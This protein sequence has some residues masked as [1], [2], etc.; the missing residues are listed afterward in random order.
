M[1]KIPFIFPFNWLKRLIFGYVIELW[2]FYQSDQ[3]RTIFT[4]L[5]PQHRPPP[6]NLGMTEFWPMVVPTHIHLIHCQ[7]ESIDWIRAILVGIEP[8]KWFWRLETKENRPN[9]HI[10]WAV[11]GCNRAKKLKKFG[12]E[13]REGQLF[14]KVEPSYLSSGFSTD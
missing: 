8:S 11:R 4:V 3:K 6:I 12:D 14:F 1:R 10:S 13:I 9:N 5:T 2:I 7:T